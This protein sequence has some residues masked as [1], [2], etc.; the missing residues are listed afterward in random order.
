MFVIVGRCTFSARFYHAAQMK[1]LSQAI[2]VGEP[3]SDRLDYWAEGGRI[4]LPNSGVAI[5][6]SNGFHRYSRVDHPEG[7]PYFGQLSI[8]DLSPDTLTRLT[9]ADYLAGRDPA[10][11]AIVARLPR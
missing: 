11:A 5:W 1:Q 10:L 3:V 6:Y 4:V 7:Q 8:R 9:S 2:F